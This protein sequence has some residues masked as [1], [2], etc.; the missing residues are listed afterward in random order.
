M[1]KHCAKRLRRVDA[2]LCS[3]A[4][5]ARET[6]RLFEQ[7][8]QPSYKAFLD[9]ALYLADC[10]VLRLALK[11][12]ED[13]FEVVM[14]VGHE[15]GLSDLAKTLCDGSGSSKANRRLA[16]GFKTASLATIDLDIDQ[17]SELRPG[18]GKLRGII[19][20]KDLR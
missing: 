8:L 20:P 17:W 18:T 6:L 19:R 10:D 12:V 11:N 5:R 9:K 2:A 16:N 13:R 4:I 7:Y 3:T 14:L 15:P 1:A